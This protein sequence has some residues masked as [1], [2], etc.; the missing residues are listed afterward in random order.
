MSPT[1]ASSAKRWRRRTALAVGAVLLS[2]ASMAAAS[3]AQAAGVHGSGEV[4]AAVPLRVGSIDLF[5]SDET[6][7]AGGALVTS[8]ATGITTCQ[9]LMMGEHNTLTWKVPITNRSTAYGATITFVNNCTDRITG[10]TFARS[11][12]TVHNG[13]RWAYER[14]Y[15]VP[16]YGAKDPR[17][18][19]VG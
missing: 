6:G 4:S 3:P 5:V 16:G 17:V 15:R 7:D 19:R 8:K 9:G 12:F 10:Y 2:L 18:H 11:P 13:E 1:P 14:P